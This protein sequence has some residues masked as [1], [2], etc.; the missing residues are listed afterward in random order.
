LLKVYEEAKLKCYTYFIDP[1]LTK[2]KK[3][4]TQ[5]LEKIHSDYN[6]Y[7]KLC[8]GEEFWDEIGHPEVW[9]E[10]INYLERWKKEIPDMPSINFDDKPEN[11]F[12]EIKDVDVSIFRRMF[13]NE[14]ICREILPILFPEN[15][16]LRFLHKYFLQ[17]ANRSIYK[18]LADKIKEI[19]D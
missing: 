9:R 11:T 7:T 14:E 17:K 3:F 19:I 13:N 4:Y 8:Y 15:K 10:L 1:G 5:E 18:T 6:V 2:N 16:V 12:E